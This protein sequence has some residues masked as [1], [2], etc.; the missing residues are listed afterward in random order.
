MELVGYYAQLETGNIVVQIITG[1][2]P[3]EMIEGIPAADWYTNFTGVVCVPTY[4]NSPNVT[5]AGIGYTYDPATQT[6]TAPPAPE[7]LPID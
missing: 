3:T 6:F 5:P 7:P 4:Y 2:L 1:L